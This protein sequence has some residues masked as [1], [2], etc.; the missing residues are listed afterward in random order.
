MG[1]KSVKAF[2]DELDEQ[3]KAWEQNSKDPNSK[4]VQERPYHEPRYPIHRG[5]AESRQELLKSLG[6]HHDTKIK[7]ALAVLGMILV[8]PIGLFI[9]SDYMQHVGP[10]PE[11]DGFQCNGIEIV[12]GTTNEDIQALVKTVSI[13]GS[14]QT[15]YPQGFEL[16]KVLDR[17]LEVID[18]IEDTIQDFINNNSI[19]YKFVILE[20]EF[21]GIMYSDRFY[22]IKNEMVTII[23]CY[24]IP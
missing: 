3:F 6:M 16:L 23:T 5:M 21:G 2:V 4:L 20:I 17:D 13:Y 18:D 10:I 9:A 8:I 15:N 14:D 11:N 12:D 19:Q 1:K 24:P 22:Q 7:M